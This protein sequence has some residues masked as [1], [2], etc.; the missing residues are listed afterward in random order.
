MP[1]QQEEMGIHQHS[2]RQRQVGKLYKTTIQKET[3][4]HIMQ[5]NTC[6]WANRTKWLLFYHINSIAGLV[7]GLSLELFISARLLT[8]YSLEERDL[9]LRQNE[10]RFSEIFSWTAVHICLPSP[11]ISLAT[12]PEKFFS[13]SLI[14]IILLRNSLALILLF[15][16]QG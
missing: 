9:I 8:L 16:S 3:T 13:V 11:L 2:K 6:S 4:Q 15:A 7:V 10:F 5:I 1:W 14:K 12:I